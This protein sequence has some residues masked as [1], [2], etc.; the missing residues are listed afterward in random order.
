MKNK[1]V[2]LLFLSIIT[3]PVVSKAQYSGDTTYTYV[4]EVDT[5]MMYTDEDGKYHYRIELSEK[6]K[7]ELEQRA[8]A[9][10]EKFN[11]NIK[12]LWERPTP[13][14]E[15]KYGT[16]F[17]RQQKLKLD[18]ATRK[19]FIGN[20]EKY[21]EDENVIYRVYR[22]ASTNT[23]YYITNGKNG[24][25]SR[26]ITDNRQVFD[27]IERGYSVK[28]IRVK[29]V[30]EHRPVQIFISSIKN[31]KGKPQDVAKYIYKART[32]EIYERVS[33]NAQGFVPAGNLQPVAGKPGV[34]RGTIEY[35]QDFE[36][37]RGDGIKYKDRTY[38]TISY[39]VRM[40][41]G[42]KLSYWDI[43]LGDILATKTE[44]R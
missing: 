39:E 34:Y 2:I 44:A 13:E 38:R 28:R 20:A 25:E 1:A 43:K 27:T 14:D 17:L 42:G 30:V 26:D 9:L 19:L 4:S 11:N 15:K 8:I 22:N 29:E 35:Y 12:K 41:I 31:P 40:Y 24:R 32:S 16:W 37:V 3:L 33:F 6:Q 23:Y 5:S 10:V 36:G 21:C 7:R 18:T